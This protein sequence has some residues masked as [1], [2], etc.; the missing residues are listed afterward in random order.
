MLID[1]LFEYLLSVTAIKTDDF[2]HALSSLPMINFHN[3]TFETRKIPHLYFKGKL[4]LISFRV[5]TSLISRFKR[6]PETISTNSFSSFSSSLSLVFPAIFV[7]ENCYRAS[8]TFLPPSSSLRNFNLIWSQTSTG[9]VQ[10][11][12][13]QLK[14]ISI[15][16]PFWLIFHNMWTCHV[17]VATVI[18]LPA[19]NI[20]EMISS[21]SYN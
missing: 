5:H 3:L 21:Y 4:L 20:L 2:G 15:L 16:P 12:V 13:L 19:K 18:W 7:S 17:I 11:I 14:K 1:L 8:T 9:P 6:N 10:L